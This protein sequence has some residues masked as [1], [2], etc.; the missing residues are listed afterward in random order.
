MLMFS[1]VMVQVR[2][3]VRCVGFIV[4]LIRFMVRI[5]VGVMLKLVISMVRVSVRMFFIFSS[6]IRFRVISVIMQSSCWESVRC[7]C[8]SLNSNFVRYELMVQIDNIRFVVV[9][10]LCV[11]VKVMLIIFI[12][13]KIILMV[14]S[15]SVSMCIVGQVSVLLV[16]CCGWVCSGG[17]V[18]CCRLNRFILVIRNSV[19]SSGFVL[20]NQLMLRFIVSIGL[21]MQYILFI[22]DLKENVVCS[23]G[24][25]WYSLVQCVCIMVGMF[26][27]VLV[28]KVNRQSQVFGV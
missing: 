15:I 2:F 21:M 7:Q 22:I 28:S 19:V 10:L 6:G 5:I 14:V 8:S 16:W 12:V 3:L 26:G 13:L 20:V 27:I 17:L 18:L 25:F 23:F 24:E 9:L 1:L 11:L 4:C